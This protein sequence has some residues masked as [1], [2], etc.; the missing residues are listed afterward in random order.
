MATLHRIASSFRDPSG[1]VFR[2]ERRIYRQVNHLYRA[3]YDKLLASGLY[4]ELVE[5]QLLLP[6]TESNQA[7]Y[8]RDAYKV[9]CPRQL[10]L[11]SY[12][13]EWCF[14]QLKDA[15]LAT[16][17]IQKRALKR[18][19]ILKDASAYNIQF[20]DG[21]PLLIDTLSFE[22][23]QEGRAWVAYRQFCQHFLVPLTLV[24][25][26]DAR[27]SQ[28]LRVYMDGIALD[29]AASLLPK[30][31]WLNPGL[32]IHLQLQN[33]AQR[34]FAGKAEASKQKRLKRQALLHIADDLR[35]TIRGLKWSGDSTSWARYY[36][37]DSYDKAEFEAKRATVSAYLQIAEPACV[38]DL[39]ANTGEFSRIASARGAFVISVDSDPGV[40]EANYLKVKKGQETQIQ[41]LLIDLSN[42]SAAIGW[43]NQ[44]REDFASRCQADCTLALALLHHLVIGNNVPLPA[45]AAYL[46]TLSEWLII[47]FVPKSDKKVQLL[48]A[49]RQ[50]IFEHYHQAG[51]ERTYS[52]A[53]DIVQ[54]QRIPGTERTLY[55]MRRKPFS[56]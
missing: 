36:A 17:A 35:A 44:E 37:G 24:C 55:L 12:P 5:R 25:Y 45:T 39:G 9:L 41:P 54:K 29:L 40:V 21:K 20:L 52:E 16:L 28:L 19:M 53:F 48:L 8:S 18:G 46:A 56:L 10:P 27:L 1:F 4:D 7:P 31:A 38:L 11:I 6:H 15:A 51:F 23:Y 47:E 30:R 43:A 49:S 32:A 33:R 2:A 34:R 26:K 22:I 50:D 3:H 14:S 42:P 13:Y